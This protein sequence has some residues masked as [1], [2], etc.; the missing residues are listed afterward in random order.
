MSVD[1]GQA[2]REDTPQGRREYKVTQTIIVTVLAQDEAHARL[3]VALGTKH[4]ESWEF[5]PETYQR[6]AAA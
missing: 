1:A 5:E 3:L 4:W 6:V 2:P